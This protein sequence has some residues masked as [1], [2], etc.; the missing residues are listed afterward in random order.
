MLVRHCMGCDA[1]IDRGNGFQ[2]ARDHL[3]H[4]NGER[5]TIRELCGKSVLRAEMDEEWFEALLLT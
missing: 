1:E 2:I 5:S 4:C 3:Q